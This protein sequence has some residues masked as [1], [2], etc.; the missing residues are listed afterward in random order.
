MNLFSRDLYVVDEV[1]VRVLSGFFRS[2]TMLSSWT[3]ALQLMHTTSTALMTVGGI[4][5]VIIL[6]FP[7]SLVAI[8]PLAFLYRAIM[9]YASFALSQWRSLKRL[10]DTTWLPLARSSV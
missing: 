4:F 5:I 1:L 3:K 6:A 7:L 8:I 2:T 9:R 10:L